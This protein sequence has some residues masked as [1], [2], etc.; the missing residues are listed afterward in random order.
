MKAYCI[1]CGLEVEDD[2]TNCGSCGC[3]RLV[4]GENNI[5]YTRDKKTESIKCI[6]GNDSFSLVQHISMK[7]VHK[8]VFKCK[9]CNKCITIDIEVD[10]E[11]EY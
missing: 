3:T 4:L 10:Y 1:S 6:C 5:D 2:K 11:T 7:K 8:H 9:E